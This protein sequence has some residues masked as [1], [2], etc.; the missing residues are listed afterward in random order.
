MDKVVELDACESPLQDHKVPESMQ[1][2]RQLTGLSYDAVAF[3]R[4]ATSWP[5]L[6][7]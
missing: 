1:R 2:P 7:Q 6:F 3:R 5:I 4:S